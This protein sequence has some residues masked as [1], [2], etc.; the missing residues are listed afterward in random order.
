M[1]KLLFCAGVLALAASCTEDLDTISVQQQSKGITFVA[2]DGN[3]AATRG[4]FEE[5]EEGGSFYYEP[6]WWAEQDQI[7][8]LSTYT[9]GT[10]GGNSLADWQNSQAAA[11][12]KA[13]KSERL[14]EF[15]SVDANNLL[16]FSDATKKS[17]FLA[18]Y[19]ANTTIT[20]TAATTS[21][22]SAPA[23]VEVTGLPTLTTQTQKN[24]EGNG[25]YE[26]MVKY[27]YSVAQKENEYDAVGEKVNLDFQRVLSGLVFRTLNADKYT[28]AA[29]S[30]PSTFGNLLTIEAKLTG[31]GDETNS[32]ANTPAL[33][34]NDTDAA[35]T[36]TMPAEAG[37]E[38]E[39]ELAN[40][41]ITSGAPATIQA[42]YQTSTLT[43]KDGSGLGWSDAARAYMVTLPLKM[44]NLTKA[45]NLQVTYK[46]QNITFTKTYALEKKDWEAGKFY[47]VPAL[48]INDY[49][50][51]LTDETSAGSSNDRTL[52][53]NKGNFSSIFDGESIKWAGSKIA[54]STVGTI[55]VASDVTMTDAD[56][57]ALNKFT[58]LKSVEL[59]GVKSIP[60]NAFNGLTEL[61]TI[62]LP[63]VTEIDEDF[64]D[65]EF[66]ALETLNLASY[67]FANEIVNGYLF[68]DNTKISLTTLDISGVESMTPVFGIERTLSFQGYALTNVT[69]KD[70][71]KLSPNAFSGC[72]SLATINGVVDLTNGTSAFDG[73]VK[74]TKININGTVIPAF[75]F[76]GCTTLTQVLYNGKQVVPTVVKES[77]FASVASVAK[78]ASMN[79]IPFY[80]DLSQA[81]TI[82]DGAFMNSALTSDNANSSILTVGAT[83]VNKDAFNGIP[84][85][86]IKFTDAT[87]IY[88]DALANTS[89]LLQ[90][91]FVKPFTYGGGATDISATTFGTVAD[92][93]DRLILFVCS[94]QTGWTGTT[95]TLTGTATAGSSNTETFT[96]KSITIED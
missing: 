84:A 71:V 9:T 57:A 26:N 54:K 29:G 17:Q 24:I 34:Y 53:V 5:T 95:L 79:A 74:L 81:K 59:N 2:T 23:T 86:M 77:A 76:N 45:E 66:T 67:N 94:E 44:E 89:N 31:N 87:T 52:I 88:N 12:Y 7:A 25:I 85:K 4:H 75:A 96:F 21:P 68:N 64:I 51:L 28:K 69:V 46:F 15:T 58:K 49:D 93:D 37:G 50:Y 16:N 83:A 65:D 70:G 36:L 3:D 14:G 18:I 20:V 91:K 1:K 43:L 10:T 61:T 11:K 30:T 33:V 6:F 63:D 19:P 47:R 90:V 39:A 38:V 35:L 62:I 55:I 13:T 22:T 72:T 73:D 80:M 78:D 8:I 92:I 82:E 40:G 56:V 27:S 42:T 48:D 32:T 41:T 60:A